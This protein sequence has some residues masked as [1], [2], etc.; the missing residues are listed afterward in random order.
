MALVI[1]NCGVCFASEDKQ[2]EVIPQEVGARNFKIGIQLSSYR[3][4]EPGLISHSGIMYGFNGE[5]SWKV[6]DT[7]KGILIGDASIGKLIY[8][9]GVCDVTT[10]KCSDFEGLTND[11]IFR[12]THRFDFKVT[13]ELSFF[14]G[15]GYRFLY[16]RGEGSS[17][18][19][20]LGTYLFAP[21]G[22]TWTTEISKEKFFLDLEYDVFLVGTMESKVSEVN[23]TYEDLTHKQSSGSGHKIA[24]GYRKLL[25]N[26][27]NLDASLIYENWNIAA[28]NSERL[29][30]SGV[31]S[32]SSFTEPKNFSESLGV[33]V[34][35][36]F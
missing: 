28:S 2:S 1:L 36:D 8:D 6:S 15:P 29:I 4:V 31:A 22:L 13:D 30:I 34:S 16:D 3:Y 12:V 27:R 26:G 20:R 24:I 19:T 5:W 21:V 10:K 35:L 23:S 9:G 33:K 17:F 18:Y 14:T 7:V 32:N 25:N 11:F